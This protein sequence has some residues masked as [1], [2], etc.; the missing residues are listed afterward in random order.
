M[1]DN[2]Q[3]G[4]PAIH[5]L[6]RGGHFVRCC[7]WVQ[8]LRCN[9]Q[10]QASEK[11]E[12]GSLVIDTAYAG[13]AERLPASEREIGNFLRKWTCSSVWMTAMTCPYHSFVTNARLTITLTIF[14]RTHFC[15]A[16]Y[17][18]GSQ[19]GR[20]VIRKSWSISRLTQP[21]LYTHNCT[22][23]PVARKKFITCQLACYQAGRSS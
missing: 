17:K 9:H 21:G 2:A 13:P 14:Y 19:V 10:K 5:Y 22:R 15:R 18:L 7:V 1:P 16:E 11:R 8:K 6:H 4:L 23:Q 12:R 20:L 3:R